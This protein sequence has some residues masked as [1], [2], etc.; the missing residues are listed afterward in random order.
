MRGYA[1]LI[2]GL[3]VP[4]LSSMATAQENNPYYGKVIPMDEKM[5]REKVFDYES[6]SDSLWRY[7]GDK[8]AIIDFYADWCA[9]CRLT[10]SILKG[11]AREYEDSIYIFKVNVDS[12][13]ALARHYGISTIPALLFVPLAGKP[14]LR[15]G[16]DDRATY[17]R[18]I[19]ELLLK[20]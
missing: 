15:V 14:T 4:L 20:E 11:L 17:R 10:G 12:E 2:M 18:L 16:G 9:P 8:P 5:F 6:H 1:L 3:L 7:A 19:E 13:P